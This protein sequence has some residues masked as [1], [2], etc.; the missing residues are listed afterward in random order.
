MTGIDSILRLIA[1]YGIMIVISGTFL[2]AS[3]RLINIWLTGYE[4]KF[5]TKSH[6]Q[7]LSTRSTISKQIQ[8]IIENILTKSDGDRVQ[9]IEF[10]NSVMSVAYLPFRYM[11]C[12]YEVFRLG[13]SAVGHKIDRLSTSLFT[14][15]FEVLQDNEYCVFHTEDENTFIGGA[16]KELMESQHE[17]HALCALLKSPKGKAIGY[18]QLIKEDAFSNDDID[19]ILNAS[20]QIAVLLSVAD[21]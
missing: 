9:V 16:M 18:I 14:K 6:D 3:I 20:H 21:K 2:Y 13:K 11:S 19:T 4:N 12:T 15:F 1:D 10:S 5:K 17:Q 8:E 7:L